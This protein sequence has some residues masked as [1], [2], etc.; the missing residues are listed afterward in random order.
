MLELHRGRANDRIQRLAGGI[1]NEVQIHAPVR[2]GSEDSGETGDC[3]QIVIGWNRMSGP[4]PQAAGTAEEI[5]T[6]LVGMWTTPGNPV[7]PWACSATPLWLSLAR[8]ASS[9]DPQDSQHQ[10][11]TTSIHLSFFSV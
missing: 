8:T 7:G 10:S 3:Q 6:P 9:F 2:H 1:G 11:A 5:A 4:K